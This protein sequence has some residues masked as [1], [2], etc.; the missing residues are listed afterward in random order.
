[1]VAS[2]STNIHAGYAS[3]NLRGSIEETKTAAIRMS[4][5]KQITKASDD[6]AGLSIG[7]GLKTDVD[8]LKAALK[9]TSQATSILSVA[10]GILGNI[11]EILGRLRSLAVTANSGA[12]GTTEKGYIKKEM[13]ALLAEVTRVAGNTKFN[14]SAL[15][16]GNYTAK[17]FQVGV[18]SADTITVGFATAMT[19]TGLSINAIDV[20][21]DVTGAISAL[22]TAVNTVK[23]VR[24]DVGA[25]QSRFSYAGANIETSMLNTNSARADYLDADIANESSAFSGATTKVQAGV[26]VLAQVNTLPQN[27]LKLI[28]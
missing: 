6:A 2:I 5:G 25:L 20:T 15:L 11:S 28:S 23:G 19:A 12:V 8:T 13:D 17:V 7:S 10:D 26:A 27:L 24:A 21:S 3:A 14:G 22:D 1:M 18:D 9:S 4:S 16:D